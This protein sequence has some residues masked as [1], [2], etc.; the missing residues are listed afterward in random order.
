MKRTCLNCGKLYSVTVGREWESKFCSGYCRSAHW[1]RENR[2]KDLES[3]KRYN[4]KRKLD[5]TKHT[6]DIECRKRWRKNNKDK[7]Y[8][9]KRAYRARK[10][11]NGGRH[12]REE[13]EELKKRFS[14]TCQVCGRK[15]PETKM[16]ED[17]IIPL[18]KGGDDSIGNIQPLCKLCN[19]IKNNR[20]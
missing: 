5:P 16:T 11:G 8:E 6:R 20:V 9:Y 12:T 10:Y 7:K 14:Y 2:K 1:R 15:E 4:E 13:W 17:H 18:S 3:R 19:S